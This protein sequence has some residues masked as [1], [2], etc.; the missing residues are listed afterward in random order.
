MGT[1]LD[2]IPEA[3][4]GPAREW[5]VMMALGGDGQPCELNL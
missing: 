4:P 1:M 3:T 5:T 2:V